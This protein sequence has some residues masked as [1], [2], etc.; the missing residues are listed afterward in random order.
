MK[1]RTPHPAIHPNPTPRTV[2]GALPRPVPWLA[3]YLLLI[4]PVTTHAQTDDPASSPIEFVESFPIESTL[5]NEDLREA[6]EVWVEMI[7][8]A[9]SSLAFEQFY[10]SSE[11]GSRLETVIEAI[12]R[13]ADRGVTVRFLVDRRFE[14][15]YP[16]TIER[17]GARDGI[18]SRILDTRRVMGGVQHAK[19]FIVDAREVFVGSQNFDWRALDHI[20]ELGLRV[21]DERLAHEFLAIFEAD[22]ASADMDPAESAEAESDGARE[23]RLSIVKRETDWTHVTLPVGGDSVRVRPAF[24]PKGHLSD[25]SH[26]DL[27]QMLEIIDEAET[28]VRVQLLTYKANTRDKTY[29]GDLEGAL[30]NA[31]A[32]GV[33]VQLLLSHWCTRAGTIE[34]LK[35]LQALPGIEVRIL[36]PPAWSGGF[37]PFARVVHAKYLVADGARCWLGTSNWERG[38]FYQSRNMGLVIDGA[39]IAGRLDEYFVNGWESEYTETV[40]LAR[41]YPPPRVSE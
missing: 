3:V 33:S 31:A 36:T 15:L 38:Y 41:D 35:S 34:G 18:E 9:S 4:A 12:E 17:L 27:P 23:T 19:F 24:S 20:Q 16:E 10:A 7:D 13:A 30:R 11:P 22:W 40:D 37:I 14:D 2:R 26:W 25:E 28:N 32:R 1:N 6:H 29:W 21:E 39:A 5:D 8:G